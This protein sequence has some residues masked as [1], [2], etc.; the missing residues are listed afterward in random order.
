M[1]RKYVLP[2][3][4][5]LGVVF[6]I[7]MVHEGAKQQPVAPAVVRPASA[8]YSSEVAGAGIVEASTENISVATTV[9]GVVT[10][11]Y[12]KV[13]DTVKAGQP[14]YKLDDRNL[15]A[16]MLVQTAAVASAQA[17][18]K[19]DEATLGDLQNQLDFYQSVADARAVSREELDRKK[20]GVMV[21][22]AQD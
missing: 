7:F 1:I 4:A 15:Q 6:G 14:L 16:S 19:V 20:F 5:L 12:V 10:E 8:E 2:I 9:P 3:L 11:L 22:Q 18:L 13:G 17:K 21:G